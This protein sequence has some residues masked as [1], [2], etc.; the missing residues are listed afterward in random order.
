[1]DQTNTDLSQHETLRARA[2]ALGV[3]WVSLSGRRVDPDLFNILSVEHALRLTAAPFRADDG[4]VRIAIT[5]PGNMALEHQLL[6]LAGGE[7]ELAV[8]EKSDILAYLRRADGSGQVLRNVA[9]DFQPQVIRD[10][11]GGKED[12]VDLA[13]VVGQTGIVRLLNSIL[14]AALE[15]QV[16]DIHFELAEARLEL[17]YRIDGILQPATDHIDASHH[18]ELVS[19]IKVLAEL[20]IAE[21]RIPQDGRFRMRFE[22]RDI[23]FRVSVLP[24]QFGEDVVIRV[25]DKG[26]L[27]KTGDPLS[28]R[29]LGIAE[30]DLKVLLEEARAPYGL[31]LITGPT[32]SGKTTTLYGTLGEMNDGMQKIITI[33]D[34]IEYQIANVV[35]IPVNEKKGLSFA[36]GLRSILRHDPD[37]IMVGEIRDRETAEIAIQAALTGHLVLASIH[38]NNTLDVIGRF[39]HWGIDL[40]DFVAALNS[41]FAQR[42]FRRLCENCKEAD[43]EAGAGLFRA[44]GCISCS[45]TGYRGRLAALEHLVLDEEIAELIVNRSVFGNLNAARNRKGMRSLQQ[46]AEQLVQQGITSQAEVERVLG[47]RHES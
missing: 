1:M 2:A 16:S 26:S 4:T 41:I 35:Q 6:H 40:H 13:S 7:V 36:A 31:M 45:D 46:A 12:V 24:T 33:E 8:A 32:G 43:H 38:A 18:E 5:D 3:D 34:P 19:R 11:G 27:S 25:L 23:D 39:T 29:G 9:R 30:E 17:K 37:K 44:V 20:D 21:Q 47:K 14:M 10:T 15:K 28:L 22:N 42:L